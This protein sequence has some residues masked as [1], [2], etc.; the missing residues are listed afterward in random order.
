MIFP[1]APECRIKCQGYPMDFCCGEF[2]ERLASMEKHPDCEDRCQIL[3]HKGYHDC[4]QT[5]RCEWLEATAPTVLPAVTEEV[6][7]ALKNWQQEPSVAGAGDYD[8][9]LMCGVEDRGLQKNGYE[10]MRYGYDR[11]LE[12]VAEHIDPLIE[13]LLRSLEP[14]A[15][16][17]WTPAPFPDCKFT[18]C[19]LPGQCKSEGKCHHPKPVGAAPTPAA[20][21]EPRIVT[22]CRKNGDTPAAQCV[23]WGDAVAAENKQLKYK[24]A[25]FEASRLALE[26]VRAENSR[27]RGEITRLE[28]SHADLNKDYIALEQ[29]YADLSAERQLSGRVVPNPKSTMPGMSKYGIGCVDGW[30]DCLKAMLAASP[31]PATGW[32]SVGERLPEDS[33]VFLVATRSS[34]IG[35]KLYNKT[36]CWHDLERSDTYWNEQIT[37]WMPLPTAPNEDSHGR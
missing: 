12:R 7:E 3:E 27:L 6:R 22:E 18:Y 35:T 32:V 1:L 37:H 31:A 25:L 11:A 5:G 34:H 24:L 15:A 16:P 4:S 23:A 10:A 21:G 33:G 2:C 8:T 28:S 17:Q 13:A 19:D 26:D 9:G 14:V 30:N 29:S 20:A 36:D